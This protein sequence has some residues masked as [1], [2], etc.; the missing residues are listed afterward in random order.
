MFFTMGQI[1]DDMRSM[2]IVGSTA[3]AGQFDGLQRW[4][5]RMWGAP[6]DPWVVDWNMN[7]MAGGAGITVNGNAIA[8]T[9]NLIDVLLSI[10]RRIRQR[11][12]W[13]AEFSGSPIALGDMA[14]VLPTFAAHCLLNSFT[15]W[16]V[17]SGTAY[18][19]VNLQTME[20]RIFRNN[21]V[22]ADNPANL[23]GAGYI[24]L[25]GTSIPLLIHDW[26]LIG[27]PNHFDMYFLTR[28]I[29][30]RKI[31]DG[32]FLD[33][34]QTLANFA[35]TVPGNANIGDYFTLDGGRAVSYTHLTLPTTPYV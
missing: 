33:A 8:A 1:L 25:D 31:W 27:G 32:E 3:V 35:P 19:E 12:S 18:N 17:C 14:I 28:T 9:W 6:I 24:T 26:E 15:C 29:G 4:T 11:I 2:I 23:Y 16:S 13:S 20:A 7:T 30:G 10:F 21:L 34:Q 5:T 22:A